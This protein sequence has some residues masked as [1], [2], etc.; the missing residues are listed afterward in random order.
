MG[1]QLALQWIKDHCNS[2]F[3]PHIL[4]GFDNSVDHLRSAL[5]DC[6]APIG[7]QWVPGHCGISGNED[8]DQAANAARTISDHT[9]I[10]H[11]QGYLP[12]HQAA[13]HGATL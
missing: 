7:I 2:S 5:S 1:L 8:A 9:Q 11:H 3:R 6:N 13:Y 4:V 10:N 12:T